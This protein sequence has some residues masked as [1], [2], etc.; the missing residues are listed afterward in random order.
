M[1]YLGDGASSRPSGSGSKIDFKYREEAPVLT[2]LA[3]SLSGNELLA[4]LLDFAPKP[5]GTVLA[6]ASSVTTDMCQAAEQ[7]HTE[8]VSE[9]NTSWVQSSGD[10]SFPVDPKDESRKSEFVMTAG[11]RLKYKLNIW[12]CETYDASGYTGPGSG[13]SDIRVAGQQIYAIFKIG[14]TGGGHHDNPGNP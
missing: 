13:S 7:W 1:Q 2:A 11:V 8:S 14:T 12:R 5:W 10:L 6:K 3:D 9:F 4:T